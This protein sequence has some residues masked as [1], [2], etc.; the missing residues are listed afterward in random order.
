MGYTI[1]VFE[2]ASGGF[3]WSG[4]LD[5]EMDGA[6]HVNSLPTEEAAKAKGTAWAKTAIGEQSKRR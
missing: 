3:G 2:A 4:Q 1:E 6:T 5:G